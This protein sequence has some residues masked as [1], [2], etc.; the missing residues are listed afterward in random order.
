[1]N[2]KKSK[3]HKAKPKKV[4]DVSKP[5]KSAPTGPPHLDI[6]ARPMAR[7]NITVSTPAE[8]ADTRLE[9][10]SAP[11]VTPAAK[12]TVIVPF[13]AKGELVTVNAKPAPNAAAAKTPAQKP[14]NAAPASAAPS[15]EKKPAPQ[16]PSAVESQDQTPPSEDA[17]IE[18][19]S[20]ANPHRPTEQTKHAVEAAAAAAKRER[21]LEEMIDSRQFFVPINAVARKHS[22]KVSA[23]LTL[24]VLLLAIVLIDLM[25]DTGMILLVQKIPHTHF[26]SSSPSQ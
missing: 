19:V 5:K 25:L 13:E 15:A 24:L 22:I 21:E 8:P 4:M 9:P 3:A 18:N 20:D 6:P 12:R 11:P 14:A 23:G 26:F 16:E 17:Q 1:M 10:A 2:H 7:Q